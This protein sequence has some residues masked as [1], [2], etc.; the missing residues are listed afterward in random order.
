MHLFTLF[1]KTPGSAS[2]LCEVAADRM[3]QLSYRLSI[4]LMVLSI[5]SFDS[6][7]MVIEHSAEIT[8]MGI[9]LAVFVF[10][11]FPHHDQ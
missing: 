11:A 7:N 10:S 5:G 3:V 4:K 1:T 6:Q 8:G 9:V 2:L